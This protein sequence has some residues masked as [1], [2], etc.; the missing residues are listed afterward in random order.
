MSELTLV[1]ASRNVKK[2]GEI[3]ELLAGIPC[4][5]LT[6]QDF[7]ECPEVKESGRTFAD[8]AKLKAVTTAI[9]TGHLTLAD[10]SGL[11]VDALGGLPGVHSARF[12]SGDKKENA[13]DEENL[14]LLLEKLDGVPD[15]DRAARFVCAMALARPS[16]RGSAEMIAETLGTVEGRIT[17]EARGTYGFGYDPVFLIEEHGKTFGE[18]GPKVKHQISHRARALEQMRPHLVQQL[19]A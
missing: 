3:E 12:A 6:L 19:G 14:K 1:I 5:V 15:E 2:R 8:N 18:L 11:E 13:T 17:Q 7:P 4:R 10:D 16:G 9:F